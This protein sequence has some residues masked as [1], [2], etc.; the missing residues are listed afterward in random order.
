MAWLIILIFA[1]FVS[2]LLY[3]MA[4]KLVE[5]S[6]HMRKNGRSKTPEAKSGIQRK[7]HP[8]F[9]RAYEGLREQKK[10]NAFYEDAYRWMLESEPEKLSVLSKDGLRLRGDLFQHPKAR[11]TALLLPGWTDVKEYLYAEAK[12]LHDC[13]LNVLVVDERA[14]GES[15]GEYTTFGAKE[16]EDAWQWIELL[17]TMGHQKLMIMGRSMGAATTMLA[18]AKDTEHTLLCAIEDAGFTSMHDE[19][20]YFV[21]HRAGWVPPLLFSI[22]IALATPIIK[23]RAGFDV[24]AASPIAHLPECKVPML[25]I[26]GQED[27]FVPYHMMPALFKAHPGPKESLSVPGAAHVCSLLEDTAG[28]QKTVQAFIDRYYQ[29]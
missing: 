12:L 13:G 3:A 20:T 18:A 14:H 22:L 15:E 25:F 24:A 23:K 1:V 8:G 19:M 29:S 4:S 28:Y 21:R 2:T 26:H 9:L 5:D 6:L 11:G 27:R 16:S 17:K 7:E 10:G